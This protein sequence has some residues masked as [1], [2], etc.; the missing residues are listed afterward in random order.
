MKNLH[1]VFT[2]YEGFGWSIH[3]P[4]LPG[5]AAG[6]TTST[7]IVNDTPEILRFAGASTDDVGAPNVYVHEEHARTDPYGNEYLIRMYG[8]PNGD[9]SDREHLAGLAAGAV[10]DGIWTDAE[11]AKQPL[12]STEERLIIVALPTDTLGWIRD[13]MDSDDS[14]TLIV[15]APGVGAN[16]VWNVPYSVPGFESNLGRDLVELGLSDTSTVDE[17]LRALLAADAA[18]PSKALPESTAFRRELTSV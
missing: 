13:Q 4:Q 6:R 15:A 2:N 1:L 16:A 9:A 12:L 7:D 5:L 8:P 11:R 18:V 17:M 10:D 3:S 14:A